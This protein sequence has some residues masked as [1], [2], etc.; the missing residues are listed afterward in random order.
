MSTFCPVPIFATPVFLTS[1][2]VA[3]K[4]PYL[5]LLKCLRLRKCPRTSVSLACAEP[6][7][8]PKRPVQSHVGLGLT[9][10]LQTDEA[11]SVLFL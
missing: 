6:W 7:G 1:S 4:L 3:I 10:K 8:P 11:L 5:R 9:P 2:F